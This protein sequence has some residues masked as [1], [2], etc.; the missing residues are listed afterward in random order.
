MGIKLELDKHS[1][2]KSIQPQ[3]TLVH[4]GFTKTCS[5]DFTSEVAVTTPLNLMSSSLQQLSHG[6]SS[7]TKPWFLL[8]EKEKES[9]D[10]YVRKE[11]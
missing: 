1:Y 4:I 3:M 8:G 6:T 5:A 2:A 7:F 11:L 9:E 10:G